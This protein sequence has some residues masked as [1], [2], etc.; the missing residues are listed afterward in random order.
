MGNFGMVPAAETTSMRTRLLAAKCLSAPACSLA[1]MVLGSI[2]VP[3]SA[4][5][6]R[7]GL[8]RFYFFKEL[9]RVERCGENSVLLTAIYSLRLGSLSDRGRINH[10]DSIS[11]VLSK[12][13][14]I[15]DL[16]YSTHYRT[17]T[18]LSFEELKV[19]L[20]QKVW[21]TG[22]INRSL[23]TMRGGSELGYWLTNGSRRPH[24]V[25]ELIGSVAHVLRRTFGS[26]QGLVGEI[27]HRPE[28][29]RT[30][31]ETIEIVGVLDGGFCSGIIRNFSSLE[32]ADNAPIDTEKLKRKQIRTEEEPLDWNFPLGHQDPIRINDDITLVRLSVDVTGHGSGNR[33]SDYLVDGVIV[34]P[35]PIQLSGTGESKITIG[36]GT[37]MPM[38][39]YNI[40]NELLS[41][42]SGHYYVHA[43]WAMRVTK[44]I[45]V[46]LVVN[47][48]SSVAHSVTDDSNGA[49][50]QIAVRPLE[51]VQSEPATLTSSNREKR[52]I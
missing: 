38:I 15:D 17:D 45:R 6:G 36:K 50:P 25:T 4:K 29:L 30:D 27:M 19:M 10:E 49:T 26:Y 40:Y 47:K 2:I 24:H 32:E 52:Q 21:N 34:V 31:T 1:S 7:N 11:R 13:D 20:D 51:F 9:A 23:D 22:A 37:Y 43:I 44:T 39:N 42:N 16:A 8:A 12:V 33:L 35:V 14:E 46:N 5:T 3:T 28:L 41:T 48:Y 18:I